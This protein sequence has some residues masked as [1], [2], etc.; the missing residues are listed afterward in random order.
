MSQ[1][2]VVPDLVTA[3]GSDGADAD[4]LLGEL[5]A[6]DD[7]G[8]ARRGRPHPSF[9][10]STMLLAPAVVL[11]GALVLYPVAR[12]VHAS[13]TD[14]DGN[15]VGLRHFRSALDREGSAR[16]S[17]RPWCGRRWCRCW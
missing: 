11:V 3:K 17:S 13:L 5:V 6:V 9:W 12:T 16:P 7:V 4:L 1:H 2:V 15:A 14:R 10:A 8:A